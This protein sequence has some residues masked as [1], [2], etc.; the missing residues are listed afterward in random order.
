M[1]TG[2]I[3]TEPWEAAL[4]NAILASVAGLLAWRLAL[5]VASVSRLLPAL[6]PWGEGGGPA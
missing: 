6:L 5:L 1:T 4:G 3:V 2:F